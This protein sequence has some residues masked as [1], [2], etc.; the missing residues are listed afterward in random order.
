MKVISI[1]GQYLNG[2]DSIA[3]YLASKLTYLSENGLSKPWERTAFADAVKKVFS[4]TF[5][6]DRDFI[7]EWKVKSEPPP[8]FLKTIRESLQFIGDGFRSIYPR[9]WL[10]KCFSDIKYPTVISDGRYL[11]EL[12]AVQ[13]KNG[14]NILVYRAGHLNND[15]NGSEA[16]LRPLIE[17]L[18]YHGCEGILD[19]HELRSLPDWFG[20]IGLIDYF[21]R[22]DGTL[23][24][25]FKKIDEELLPYIGDRFEIYG[26]IA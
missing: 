19:H 1:V 21:I 16:H 12:E 5:G 13:G 3:D 23:E 22:N 7:E 25:L 9:I 24:D 18:I 11:N 6:K 10:E 4:Q 20:D 15:P 8:G 2:K 17:F 14:V 26:E